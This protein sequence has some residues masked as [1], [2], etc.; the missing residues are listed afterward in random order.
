MLKQYKRFRQLV[1]LLLLAIIVLTCTGCNTISFAAAGSDRLAAEPVPEACSSGQ[2]W[3]TFPFTAE[4]AHTV[5][6]GNDSGQPIHD[7]CG[8]SVGGQSTSGSSSK[9]SYWFITTEENDYREINE[10]KPK[11]VLGGAHNPYRMKFTFYDREYGMGLNVSRTCSIAFL[12]ESGNLLE[13][14]TFRPAG[15]AVYDYVLQDSAEK[16]Q[17]LGYTDAAEIFSSKI[18]WTAMRILGRA[19]GRPLETDEFPLPYY[20]VRYRLQPTA[21]PDA[22]SPKL[23]G[24]YDP[25]ATFYYNVNGKLYNVI[26][27]AQPEYE[28]TA[29]ADVRYT[30]EEA[31]CL[32]PD[33][34]NRPE[35]ILV[36]TYAEPIP[37]Q[38]GASDF[39]DCWTFR[40]VAP[41]ELYQMSDEQLESTLEILGIAGRYM[42]MQ[43]HVNMYT[44]EVTGGEWTYSPHLIHQYNNRHALLP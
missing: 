27:Y 20:V 25:T 14:I 43:C 17:A 31:F 32:L 19:Q 42:E 40:F 29:S 22:A 28:V 1:A 44:G 9:N 2:I 10:L 4:Q 15:D 34:W 41:P 7:L 8:Y 37:S 18:D 3:F 11:D 35:C 36:D 26:L 23:S 24:T 30:A 38:K 6:F 12:P 5:F 21:S 13:A 16:L 33:E 39:A